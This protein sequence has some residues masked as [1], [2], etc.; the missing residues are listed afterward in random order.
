MI[1]QTIIYQR[2]DLV[3][4][5]FIIIMAGSRKLLYSV[6]HTA[7]TAINAA[8]PFAAPYVTMNYSK[9]RVCHVNPGL[10]QKP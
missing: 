8:G 5:Y 2:T 1:D 9:S 6:A 10:K 7:H 3:K 4:R